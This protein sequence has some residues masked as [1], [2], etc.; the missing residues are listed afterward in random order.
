MMILTKNYKAIVIKSTL[1][2]EKT[3]RT[4]NGVQIITLKK[5][6]TVR[7]VCTDYEDKFENTKGYKKIKI[8]AVGVLIAEKD[9]NA[10]QLKID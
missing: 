6:D 10:Q 5:G 9:I 1:I 7:L 2:P 3:T 8:P 4:S